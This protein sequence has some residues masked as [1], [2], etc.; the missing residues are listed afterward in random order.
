MPQVEMD[1]VEPLLEQYEDQ[2]TNLIPILQEVQDTYRYLP[3]EV[4]KKIS[5][6][7]RV[8]TAKIRQ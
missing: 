7:L 8:L 4:L 5:R 3:Q 6:K 2:R 1:K